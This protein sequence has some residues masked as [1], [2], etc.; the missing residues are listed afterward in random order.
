VSLC[1]NPRCSARENYE[2][3]DFC[4]GCGSSLLIN[5]RFKVI[6]SLY[7]LN[8]IHPTDIYEAMDLVGTWASPPNTI[9]ILKVLKTNEDRYLRLFNREA[10]TLQSFNKPFLPRVDIDD[11]FV[12]HLENGLE[13]LHCLALSKIEGM[14]MD[15]WIQRNGRITQ[16]MCI[17]WLRQ[18]GNILHTIHERGFFHRDIKPHNI[19]VQPDGQLALIDFGGVREVT[20]TYLSKISR[21]HD[22]ELTEIHTLG[23]A[24]PEQINGAALPQSDFYALGRTLI[25][26]VTGEYFHKLPRD[27]KTAELQ[28]QKA[29]RHIDKPLLKF[30][31]RLVSPSPAK[32]PQNTHEIL[33]FVDEKLSSQLKWQ[34]RIKSKTFRLGC[35][36]LIVL[37]AVAGIHITRLVMANSYLMT[38]LQQL[39][40]D[41]L[42]E[43]KSNFERSISLHPTSESYTNMGVLCD[44]IK[45]NKCAL[46]S[47]TEAIKLNPRDYGAYYN[48]GTHYEDEGD[49]QKAIAAYRKAIEVSN[50][51]AIEPLNNLSRLLIF[52]QGYAE[53]QKMAEAGLGV[54]NED[55]FRA[56]LYKNLGW[57]YL[58]QK[59]YVGAETALRR[60]I[61][62]TTALKSDLA[63][64]HCLLAQVL[65]AQ[66]QP[67]D[68]ER[69][70][71]LSTQG[72][73]ELNPEVVEW[74]SIFNSR[75]HNAI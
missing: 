37:L 51:K 48:L 2:D 71:C 25:V 66:K 41:R 26:A 31:E 47:Y 19:M 50:A 27:P 43:A 59:N 49:S 68:G 45:D 32:R 6:H 34:Q 35:L 36:F 73:D 39:T 9:K 14:T 70:L 1:I 72:E 10:K 20:N 65:E 17:D 18:M 7:D 54:A 8:R 4:A 52:Q 15:E 5:D 30:I 57:A 21:N 12:A 23:F 63:S 69:K 62:L 42:S 38:G 74:R 61:S 64:G 75:K 44:R 56:I 22:F 29:A 67:A 46:D 40:N 58:G 53:A 24:A 3:V 28:W 16:E 11:Y 13:E 55:Y 60:S 33:T